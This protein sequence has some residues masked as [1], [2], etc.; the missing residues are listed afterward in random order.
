MACSIKLTHSQRIALEDELRFSEFRDQLRG[1]Y[2]GRN[3]AP[4]ISLL[5]DYILGEVIPEYFSDVYFVQDGIDFLTDTTNGNAMKAAIAN[6]INNVVTSNTSGVQDVDYTSPM[7]DIYGG[8]VKAA[9]TK[10]DSQSKDNRESSLEEEQVDSTEVGMIPSP[11]ALYQRKYKDKEAY[12]QDRFKASSLTENLFRGKFIN[13]FFIKA[14]YADTDSRKIVSQLQVPGQLSEV[15]TNLKAK[16]M[17]LLADLISRLNLKE[18][19]NGKA[20]P[21][22]IDE[23]ILAPERFNSILRMIEDTV[24]RPTYNK[25]SY[26]LQTD[27]VLFEL[28][29]KYKNSA[30]SKTSDELGRI[31]NNYIDYVI[32]SD[33]DKILQYYFPESI[34]VN[35]RVDPFDKALRKYDIV[36]ATS[37]DTKNVNWEEKVQDGIENSAELYKMIIDSTPML[38]FITGL[39]MKENLYPTLVSEIFS[40][41]FS[42]VDFQNLIPSIKSLVMEGLETDSNSFTTKNVLYT[43]YKKFFEED[44]DNITLNRN[45]VEFDPQNRVVNSLLATARTDG[46]NI[47]HPL[48][49]LITKPLEEINKVFYAEALETIRDRPQIVYASTNTNTV[50]K[51]LMIKKITT[52][53]NRDSDSLNEVIKS[54]KLDS[55]VNTSIDGD[56]TFSYEGGEH[57]L[58]SKGTS[59]YTV[60]AVV[61]LTQGVLGLDLASERPSPDKEFYEELK[62]ITGANENLPYSFLQFVRSATKLMLAKST[63]YDTD[64]QN[65]ITTDK[66]AKLTGNKIIDDMLIGKDKTLSLRDPKST[67]LSL[68]T[69]LAHEMYDLITSSNN[70]YSGN[71]VK[72]TVTTL[73]GTSV[74][75]FSLYNYF[76]GYKNNIAKNKQ[77]NVSIAASPENRNVLTRN[78]FFNDPDLLS[79][80]FIRGAIKIK[81]QVKSNS[82]HTVLET[83]SYDINLGYFGLIDKALTDGKE[84][85]AMFDP[86]TY[87]DKT[88]NFLAN[89]NN[90]YKGPGGV[91]NLFVDNNGQAVA[92]DTTLKL[93]HEANAGYY[94]AYSNN[95]IDTWT[96]IL[97]TI[98]SDESIN[99]TEVEAFKNKLN[100]GLTLSGKLAILNDF[101]SKFWEQDG[102]PYGLKGYKAARYYADKAGVHLTNWIHYQNNTKTLDS[103]KLIVKPQLI[104]YVKLFDQGN[105]TASFKDYLDKIMIRSA[106]ELVAGGFKFQGDALR[107]I[108]KMYPKLGSEFTENSG[109]ILHLKSRVAGDVITRTSEINPAFRKFFYDWNFVSEN[110]L[111]SSLGSIYSHKGGSDNAMFTTMTKRNVAAGASMRR[112]TL[113]LENGV[114]DFTRTAFVDDI[115][116]KL[117]TIHGAIDTVVDLDGSAITTMTQR[118]KTWNSLNAP[119]A[120]DGGVDQKPFT[121]HFDPKTGEVG[122]NKFADFVMTNELIRNSI[123]SDIDLLE[124]HKEL[125]ST[126]ISKTDITQ[127]WRDEVNLSD[128]TD[129]YK[130]DRQYDYANKSAGS[131]IKLHSI[132]FA[133]PNVNGVNQYVV[134]ESNL[135]AN[136]GPQTRL[137]NIATMYDLWQA[138]GGIDSV[139]LTD[140]KT[141]IGFNDGQRQLYVKESHTS[142]YK[143][144][145]FEN[146]MGGK[147]DYILPENYIPARNDKDRQ[148]YKAYKRMF[149]TD[150]IVNTH[151]DLLLNSVFNVPSQ[152]VLDKNNIPTD[153]VTFAAFAKEYNKQADDMSKYI[154]NDKADPENYF[155]WLTKRFQPFKG[156]NIERL[157]TAGA[158]KVG[159][160]NMNDSS[161]YSTSRREKALSGLKYKQGDSIPGVTSLITHQ[162]NNMNSGVQL[163]AFHETEGSTVTLPTQMFNAFAFKGNS[164]VDVNEIY[165]AIADIVEQG[166]TDTFFEGSTSGK[167]VLNIP[168]LVRQLT[169]GTSSPAAAKDTL[170][171]IFKEVMQRKVQNDDDFTLEQLIVDTFSHE[172]LPIDDP[173]MFSPAVAELTNYFTKKGIKID[174]DGMFAILSPGSGMQQIRE[175]QGGWLPVKQNGGLKYKQLINKTTLTSEE[176]KN[177]LGLNEYLNKTGDNSHAS[178]MT[179]KQIR[180]SVKKVVASEPRDLKG[181]QVVLTNPNGEVIDLSI[182]RSNE[183]HLIPEAEALFDIKNIVDSHR[184]L[185]ESAEYKILPLNQK[186]AALDNYLSN[187]KATASEFI[188]S[189][190]RAQEFFN[191]FVNRIA[192]ST[193]LKGVTDYYDH[194]Y[195]MLSNSKADRDAKIERQSAEG[196]IKG[197]VLS[198]QYEYLDRVNVLGKIFTYELQGFMEEANSGVIPSSLLGKHYNG[199]AIAEGAKLSVSRGEVMAPV[200]MKKAFLLRDGDSLSDI[201]REFFVQR[202][203]ENSKRENN[204]A[205]AMLESNKGRAVY[206]HKGEAPVGSIES[207]RVIEKDGR[208]W[209]TDI[210]TNVNNEPFAY[211]KNIFIA[212]IQGDVH[213]YLNNKHTIEENPIVKNLTRLFKDDGEK[214]KEITNFDNSPEGLAEDV[215]RKRQR[216]ELQA[217]KMFHS[218]NEY[219]KIIGTRIPGQHFQSFQGLKIVGFVEGNKVYVP[220]EVTLL[221]G[222]D[223]DI[224]KQNIIYYSVT[225]D[226]LIEKWHPA[227]NWDTA[228]NLTK[229]L[230]LPLT[231]KKTFDDYAAEIDA[232]ERPLEPVMELNPEADML[233]LDTV[234]YVYDQLRKGNKLHPV[235]HESIINALMIYDSRKSLD[236]DQDGSYI[237]GR[238]EALSLNGIKNFAIAKANNIIES[239]LNFLLLYKPVSMDT[240]KMFGDNSEKGA[241]SKLRVRENPNS[242]AEAKYDNMVGKKV[243]G[244]MAAGG[245]KSLSALTVTYNNSLKDMS[246]LLYKRQQLLTSLQGLDPIVNVDLINKLQTNIT[247]VT[248]DIGYIKAGL[249]GRVSVPNIKYDGLHPDIVNELQ[250]HPTDVKT[251]AEELKNNQEKYATVANIEQL[252]EAALN[253][254]SIRGEFDADAAELLSELLSAATDNAKELILAKIN[255]TP[256][257]A[258]IYASMIVSNEPFE[259]IVDV[260]TSPVIEMLIK[261]AGRNL[262]NSNTEKNSLTN[263]LSLMESIRNKKLA[264]YKSSN[265]SK[266]LNNYGL[267]IVENGDATTEWGVKDWNDSDSNM[268]SVAS[269]LSVKALFDKADDLRLLSK[270]LGI[271]QG[272]RSNSWELYNFK[273]TVQDY[274]NKKLGGKFDFKRF[275]DSLES[276]GNYHRDMV[277]RLSDKIKDTSN[278]NPLYVLVSTPNFAKQLVAY[279]SANTLLN[280]A[281]YKINTV[282]NIVDKLRSINYLPETQ[283]IN[284]TQYRELE[285]FIDNTVIDNFITSESDMLYPTNTDES[286]RNK[287]VFYNGDKQIKITTREGRDEFARWVVDKF[288]PSIKEHYKNNEFVQELIA[289]DKADSYLNGKFSFMHLTMDTTNVKSDQQRA[290][291]DSYLYNLGLLY[292]NGDTDLQH[293]AAGPSDTSKQNNIFNVLFWYNMVI[294]KN[295]I[296]KNSYAKLL[297]ELMLRNPNDN[298]Y[299]RFLELKGRLGKAEDVKLTGELNIMTSNGVQFDLFDLLDSYEVQAAK[300]DWSGASDVD[301]DLQ[302]ALADEGAHTDEGTDEDHQ[303]DTDHEPDVAVEDQYEGYEEGTVDPDDIDGEDSEAVKKKKLTVERTRKVGQMGTV[304]KIYLGKPTQASLIYT[305][306]AMAVPYMV[307]PHSSRSRS[308]T[309]N[310]GTNKFT[311]TNLTVNETDAVNYQRFMLMNIHQLLTNLN[312]NVEIQI[313][314]DGQPAV[315]FDP[316]ETYN[317]L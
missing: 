127:S 168:E 248:N 148:F 101:N 252:K 9:L 66:G 179:N 70:R 151:L 299:R 266:L 73:E 285:K 51:S 59:N 68:S 145:D 45:N 194:F 22:I 92:E 117:K 89:V 196:D 221:S 33:Y 304:T 166:L 301:V 183:Q 260:M 231:S 139:S 257:L 114:E 236:R 297:G 132:K 309:M 110:L 129:V 195:N 21:V 189:N 105:N 100:S 13:D 292:H 186:Q 26:D 91:V 53:I 99:L 146:Y 4:D 187:F 188:A 190:P 289:D 201:D 270:Y 83:L 191:R 29:N 242:I 310:I 112:F 120:G 308:K 217:D 41:Y 150:G 93:A 296:T 206:F 255:A 295:N 35:K 84:V 237:A 48:M 230:Q 259:H 78:A 119:F 269:L 6:M 305:S 25:D 241:A 232:T 254:L 218:W 283:N 223:F 138:L 163:S 42:R 142:A 175:V 265:E 56:L 11:E 111:N 192:Q 290:Y 294:N 164:L 102:F 205:D 287:P 209:F 300:L 229:S 227:F 200:V 77:Q 158:Q 152:E 130:W 1:Y 107:A 253:M 17:D 85:T 211:P 97:D 135:T 178:E 282:Y 149:K 280:L 307:I 20:V 12:I 275:L 144:L 109:T 244:I 303:D 202:L 165:N 313:L 250:L 172:E 185:I 298:P 174:F 233:D 264:I 16:R 79:S 46:N 169:D 214:F 14:V 75:G 247:N 5:H 161:T 60:D 131:I 272:I 249:L 198:Y 284:E 136:S 224:D 288:L 95:I 49:L 276:G 208:K 61:A 258:G 81:D 80:F 226:G 52:S 167:E 171:R 251:L 98:P 312:G 23:T 147:A 240:P 104:D 160:F 87:S 154:V 123:G 273:V 210:D 203:L 235:D 162:I 274:V 155:K 57:T 71:R 153:P 38:N 316:N 134:T 108:G 220:N 7:Y 293:G 215:L 40:K 302:A 193:D 90:T 28:S 177:W 213:V 173:H 64:V 125:Y 243:I 261:N 43:M 286:L 239:P 281:S 306:D 76:L 115:T 58:S 197:L 317:C 238:Q 15:D 170:L 245:L 271:N 31:V 277:M 140:E 3:N 39:P 212:D 156:R 72:S 184:D 106:N 10:V 225:K 137:V 50:T 143:L 82:N 96:S 128:F 44:N 311:D 263:L 94:R 157:T 291:R 222:S 133:G 55:S 121:T 88:T 268:Y 32:V 24:M 30:D 36:N 37:N 182:L 86:T 74:A 159:Q 122:I 216:A 54:F 204:G 103:P 180:E 27:G 181:Q 113:G 126:D 8:L 2:L 228:E 67:I 199:P 116:S 314:R 246:K 62:A 267:K 141:A 176:Y 219:T 63:L 262:F 207:S 118:I 315:N 18:V 65:I 19:V 256:D 47:N 278:F 124:L 234:L 69:P 279:N 34:A